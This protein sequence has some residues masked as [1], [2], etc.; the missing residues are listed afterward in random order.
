MTKHALLSPS[1]AHRWR[2]CPASAAINATYPSTSSE[3]ADEGTAAHELASWALEA[4][5]DAAGY[6]GRVIEVPNRDGKSEPRRFTV[7]G[8]M[9]DHV[10]GYLD[11]TRAWLDFDGARL[12]VEQSL[13]IDHITGEA[14]ATGTGDAVVIV[15]NPTTGCNDIV[16][17]DLKFGRGV[18]VEAVENDQLLMYASGALE[19]FGL[20]Y[21]FAPESIVRVDI[22]QPRRQ[23]RSTWAITVAELRERVAA[24]AKD[25]KA[26]LKA[27]VD[28]KRAAGDWCKFCP[29]S[30]TCEAHAE[31]VQAAML[32]GFENLDA[33]A[34][35]ATDAARLAGYLSKLESIRAWCAAVEQEANARL[36]RGESLPGYKLVRG[37]AG[38][39]AWSDE[40]AAVTALISHGAQ[41]KDIFTAPKLKSPA[42]AEKLIP[43]EARALLSPLITRAEG[44]PTIAP[45]SDPRPLFNANR[46]EGL[47]NLDDPVG[48]N[49]L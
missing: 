22:D 32:D 39:R 10:Q 18:Q 26:A 13:P 16:V 46:T 17:R 1:S 38:D 7:D 14:G 19:Q 24:V 25:A 31:S 44:K 20:A 3:F 45:E 21:D 48:A 11:R 29:A 15:P 23:H 35:A 30:A 47:D 41:R 9:A 28:G 42:Q 49:L 34:P 40:E 6:I 12:F 33:P 5:D 37:K 2:N 43:K 36:L 8:D 4:G 27:G